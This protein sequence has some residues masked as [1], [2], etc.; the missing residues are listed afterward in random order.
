MKITPHIG[1]TVKDNKSP[2][3]LFSKLLCSAFLFSLF[4]ASSAS[5]NHFRYANFSWTRSGQ[6][7]TFT[8]HVSANN[9][10]NYY[11]F[12]T[13]YVVGHPANIG[14]QNVNEFF[15]F[16][17]GSPQLT[18][19]PMTID[20]IN[21]A[22][23]WFA[24]T[25]VI[26]H[27]YAGN[28]PVTAF[29]IGSGARDGTLSNNA[30]Q[31]YRVESIVNFVPASPGSPLPNNSPISTMPSK[32]YLSAG[33][34]PATFNIAAFDPDGNSLSFTLSNATQMGSPSATQP[35]SFS[36]NPLTGLA[37]FVTLGKPLGS[38]WN[39]AVRIMDSNGAVI[40]IDVV[41]E[42]VTASTPPV[43]IAPTPAN[44]ST[45]SV[46]AGSPVTF[47]VSAQDN[48]PGDFVILT[49]PGLPIGATMTPNLPQ[50]GNPVTSTL[51]WTPTLANVGGHV[52]NFTAT[53]GHSVQSFNSV[54][55]LVTALP[56]FDVPPT[57]ALNSSVCIVPGVPY[58]QQ[59]K[60][61]AVDPAGTVSI[62]ALSGPASLTAAPFPSPN[63][64]ISSTTLNWTPS[65][66][67]WGPHAVTLTAINSN[68]L[69]ATH[70]FNITVNTPPEYIPGFAD[71]RLCA[72]NSATTVVEV[73]DPDL[74]F[75]DALS[76]NTIG[77]PPFVT[78]F[79]SGNTCTFSIN[80]ALSNGGIYSFILLTTDI[81]SCT[82]PITKTITITVY[83]VIDDNN[84]CTIDGCDDLNGAVY[85]SINI[86]DNDPCTRDGCEP[87]TG[88]THES[89]MLNASASY[90]PIPCYGG[91]TS[92]NIQA[93]GGIP[94][95]SGEGAFVAGSGMQSYSVMDNEGCENSV[96]FNIPQP[97]KIVV[98]ASSSASF[99]GQPTAIAA[100]TA[101]GGT[102]GY[103]FLWSNGMTG[104]PIGGLSPGTYSVTATDQNGCTESG[105]T[106]VAL[107]GSPPS[108]P[109]TISGPV[110]LCKGQ[111]V[112]LTANLAAGQN[113]SSFVWTVPS[114]AT[115]SG[116]ANGQS[117]VVCTTTKYKGGFIC[118]SG[119]NQCGVGQQTCRLFP[120]IIAVPAKPL[121]TGPANVC[122]PSTQTYCISPLANADN[123]IW[124]IDGSAT[125]SLQIINQSGNCVTVNV[126]TGY[127]GHQ[128]VKVYG[129]NCKGN[130]SAAYI[131][132][133]AI[134]KPN[135]PGSISGASSSCKSL[136]QNYSI[137]AVTGATSYFWSVSGGGLVA[138][139]QGT[140]NVIVDFILCNSS[141]VVISVT[142]SNACGTSIARTKS[143]SLNL[144]CRTIS[145]TETTGIEF[146]SDMTVYPIP[147]SDR[148]TLSCTST[149]SD[150]LHVRII[151]ALGSIVLTDEFNLGEGENS[152]DIYLSAFAKGSY[153]I[154]LSSDD[155]K[156]YMKR[157]VVE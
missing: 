10:A 8:I 54:N 128:K 98:T 2:R 32:I 134:S 130:G 34:N 99:C 84:L 45:I 148:I 60:V 75:G 57:P 132:V 90:S 115:I 48:D 31:T 155:G 39:T 142:A 49:A 36:V 78:S 56:V 81:M 140:T 50:N 37:S 97:E 28:L 61:H 110:G 135:Q 44:A 65:V 145:A 11:T 4:F 43:F 143:V 77:M 70:A 93:T 129:T 119:I 83:T 62:T 5:A 3:K 105:S 116:P 27:T 144:N 117:I 156:S 52:I 1:E 25:Q 21:V 153:F 59:V 71:V 88:A 103:S 146:I 92:V 152:K 125:P 109:I 94:P 95:Y 91:T 122:V 69:S 121:L 80:P 18:L 154:Q 149:K 64:N 101:I 131:E 141:P 30:G 14:P 133:K 74:A 63:Q 112:T 100:A 22:E 107:G 111:C 157:I 89:T 29:L 85:S 139:G 51:N 12:P 15:N 137:A 72:G 76:F 79:P 58:T 23:G 123:I 46:Q 120:A 9:L 73:N 33:L 108:A 6:T 102:P 82:P 104:T 106:T 35:P 118:V 86:D 114:G 68:N 24:A 42:I 47:T 151:D 126:P 66:S 124:L 150:R 26:T 38:E 96:S 127:N 113:P 19:F 20:Q 67:D 138:G 55:I 40:T 13:G 147:T 17:D 53:D 136:L 7:V 16:G 41:M 87:L